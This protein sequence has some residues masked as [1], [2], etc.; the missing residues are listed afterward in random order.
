MGTTPQTNLSIIDVFPGTDFVRGVQCAELENAPEDLV[1][2]SLFAQMRKN[3]ESKKFWKFEVLKN[4]SDFVLF[5]DSQ[6]TKTIPP[7]HYN[8]DVML[9]HTSGVRSILLQGQVNVIPT[10][11]S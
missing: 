1:D 9:L 4:D 10:Y 11:T 3:H 5:M 7:G 8:Y 6:I 2:Y